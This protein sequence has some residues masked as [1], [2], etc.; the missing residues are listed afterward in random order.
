MANFLTPF[1][2]NDET[3]EPV[4][5]KSFLSRVCGFFSPLELDDGLFSTRSYIVP[6]APEITIVIQNINVVIHPKDK[7]QKVKKAKK[8]KSDVKLLS[9]PTS[10]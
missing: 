5:R 1:T 6:K 2:V 7:Q 9:S 4:K 10:I 3:V 8:V